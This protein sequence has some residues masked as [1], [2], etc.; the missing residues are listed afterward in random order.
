M[1]GIRVRPESVGD[2]F[3]ER[4]LPWPAEDVLDIAPIEATETS[5]LVVLRDGSV[6]RLDADCDSA[7]CVCSIELPVD[8]PD[9]TPW[10][11]HRLTPRLQTSFDATFAA[12]VHDYGRDGRVHDL[13]TGRSAIELHGGRS[14]SDTVPFSLVFV[15]DLG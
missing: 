6:E 1:P 2:T 13:R 9:H 4:P 7:R 14:H 5:W 15:E 11:G 3:H 10:A 8:E 12:I